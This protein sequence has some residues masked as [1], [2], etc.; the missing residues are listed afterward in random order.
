MSVGTLTPTARRAP[1]RV[2][3]SA[4]RSPTGVAVLGLMVL[5]AALRFT[6]IGHQGFWFDEGNTALLVSYSPGKMLGLIPQSESTPPLYYCLA[7]VWVRVFGHGE[8][9]L[10]S[11]SALAGVAVIPVAYAAAAKLVSRR[12]GL[13][14]AAL[15]TCNPFLIWYSQEARSYSLLVFFSACTLLAFAYARADPHPRALVL[16]VAACVL[17][18]LTHYYTIVVVLPQAAWLLWEH[19]RTRGAWMA[20]GAVGLSGLALLP[21]VI[22]Q[23]G[24]GND[25]WIANTPLGL[26]LRQILPQ[27]LIGT[28]APSREVVTL[29]AFG[30]ALVGLALLVRARGGPERR[31]AL[32]AGALALAGFILALVFVA[33]GKDTL[34][35]RNLLGLWLPVAVLVGGGL[36][37]IGG[38][39]R[40][41]ALGVAATAGLCVI[42]IVATVA[43]ATDRAMQRPD[44]RYVSRALGPPPTAARDPGVDGRA[45]LIQHYRAL[46]PLSL[47]QPRLAYLVGPRGA[48]VRELDIISMV[49][50]TQ[51]L[52]WWGAACNLIPSDMQARYAIP[53]FHQAWRRHV[54]QWTILRLVASRPVRLTPAMA[55]AAL[56]T[57]SLRRDELLLERR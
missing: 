51:Q 4:V 46:L 9:G 6:R 17:S 27:F 54:L 56:H 20:I 57:T 25:S 11:F 18:L 13:I 22:S 38:G 47:Y 28:N 43:I 24:T 10:R 12:A 7:W 23:A 15:A 41:R 48:V 26:R 37:A 8:A 31:G 39:P 2:S 55:S 44:W 53:G 19:R 45:I 33:A 35:T 16:W 52:C 42:G 3:L 5:G 14:V 1:I 40:L 30:L 21:L 50:P 29:V 49:S 34:I 32:L 36:S